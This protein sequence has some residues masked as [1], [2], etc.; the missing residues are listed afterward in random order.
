MTRLTGQLGTDPRTADG[1]SLPRLLR[2]R[3]AEF[4]ARTAMRKK[5]HG[6]WQA[7]SWADVLTKVRAIAQGLGRL[8]IGRGDTVAIISENIVEL[9]WI[10][11]AAL[12]WGARVVCL[13]PD[14]TGDELKYILDH[15]QARIVVAEDQEQTD[16]C[17]EVAD[18]LPLLARIAYID[19][20]GLWHY[21]D[22]RLMTFAALLEEGARQDAAS[23]QY[24]DHAADLAGQDDDAIIC[25]TSGT[26]GLPKGVVL[27][28]RYLLDNAY[29]LM[30]AFKLRP[31]AEYL[32]YISPA[33]AAEQMTGLALCL[34]AP[35][36]VNFSEKPETVKA[37]LRE[38]GPEFLLFTPRQW[39]SLA[40][41]VQASMLDAPHWRRAL[42]NWAIDVK[43]DSK[44]GGLA[45][46]LADRMVCSG[47]RDRLGLV[48]TVAA[49]S[50]GAGMSAEVFRLFRAF[51]VKLSNL[52]GSTE[53]GL[54]AAHWAGDNDPVSMGELLPSD[55]SI[56][57]PLIVALSGEGELIIEQGA[58]FR[59]YW[60][61]EAETAAFGRQGA[62]RTGDVARV[63]PNGKWVFLDRLKDMRRLAG[64]QSFP[65][66]FIENH[67]RASPFVKDAMVIGDETRPFVSA[68]VN[69]NA[70]IAGRFAEQNGLAYGTFGELSQLPAIRGAVGALVAQ[71]N[72][73]VE[74][75]SRVRRFATL[76]K[77]LDPDEAELT[78]SRK[79]RRGQIE[80]SYCD[81]IRALYDGAP[82]CEARI[83]VTYR[84]G[85]NSTLV[86][87]VAMNDIA[88]AP[89]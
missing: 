85:R 6:V 87:R 39:E 81:I 23:P 57:A 69:I 21:T 88:D 12:C 71:V 67:L 53:L 86:A 61:D 44:A 41:D 48:R 63:Q 50:G 64:G 2:E 80:E 26:T 11:Y 83:R 62:L 49:L 42:Y 35:L 70:D 68:L 7:Y 79:L 24:F 9:Y 60:R 10:E 37:D 59:G 58:H 22:R 76:P 38:L 25:Y 5:H 34:L 75:E 45:R 84:D 46:F 52:Y 43:R 17:L 65:P 1:R 32:S 77:E 16:K 74:P 36:T 28:H 54:I 47:I 55:P 18:A 4:A 66:Q 89:A 20:R 78:R 40:A 73:L 33:W 31:G 15:S 3:A 27:T 29:R 82:E 19:D 8:G 51:G 13:Y 56:N 72:A 30:A 14:V